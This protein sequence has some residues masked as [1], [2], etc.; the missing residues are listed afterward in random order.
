[1]K[2]IV[3]AGGKATR[4]YPITKGVCFMHLPSSKTT[5]IQIIG[6]ALRLHH[7][8]TIAHIILPF[9]NGADE[10]CINNFLNVMAKTDTRIKHSY[11]HKNIGGYIEIIDAQTTI[12]NPEISLRYEMIYNSL[13][14]STNNHEIWDKRLEELKLYSPFVT[15]DSYIVVFDT[16]V[17]DLPDELLNNRPWG[18]GNNPKTAV[19]E[20]LKQTN[21]FAIDKEIENKLMLTSAPD[22]F[23]KRI[24]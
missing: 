20:F 18:K 16:F 14:E 9:S 8:K 2:G 6:R 3:L 12:N 10:Q 22:G 13:C 1:M 5:L 17:E 23:L 15:K 24:K 21:D 11:T 19:W 4:L 7:N